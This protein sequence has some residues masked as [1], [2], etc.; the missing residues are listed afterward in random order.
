MRR[1]SRSIR[2]PT[3]REGRG[4]DRRPDQV[5]RRDAGRFSLCHG[6]TDRIEGREQDREQ[7][8]GGPERISPRDEFELKND[9]Y[10]AEL[11]VF[12]ATGK[13]QPHQDLVCDLRPAGR[14]V[15]RHDR[16][17]P[18]LFEQEPEDI[19]RRDG[20]AVHA[21]AELS[22]WHGRFGRRQDG[23][24]QVRCATARYTLADGTAANELDQQEG[25]PD[26]SAARLRAW[27]ARSTAA[28]RPSASPYRRGRRNQTVK[29]IY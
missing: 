21:G 2:W 17:F 27:T 12:D 23:G 15:R 18:R 13:N 10:T 19:D 11:V 16:L 8:A 6:L 9:G 3:A 26:I 24:H 29:P 5:D 4:H 22:L 1:P 20:L 14:V 25:W 28:R 7:C